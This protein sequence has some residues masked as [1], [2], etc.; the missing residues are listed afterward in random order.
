[1]NIR[2]QDIPITNPQEPFENCK[3]DR[4]KYAEV[5]IKIINSYSD[6]FVL[7][8]NNRWG[9]GKTTF[10]RMWIQYLV[11]QKY[12]TLYFNAWE[13]DFNKDPLAAI[14]SELKTLEI[15]DKNN[16]GPLI[17]KGAK[18]SLSILPVILEA[19]A[20]KYIEINTVKDAFKKLSEEAANIF[21]EEVNEYAEKKKSLVDFKLELENY[22]AKIPKKPLVFF[23][24]ELDRCNPKYAVELLE[25]IKHF[26]SVPGIVFIVSI[27]KE[28][29][30]NSIK[31]YFGSESI[32]SE[33]YLRRFFDLEYSIPKSDISLVVDWMLE[34]YSFKN[35]EAILHYEEFR[36]LRKLSIEYLGGNNFPIRLI[37][38][39]FL[40][41][42]LSMNTKNNKE[43]IFLETM[44]I[45]LL[46][47]YFDNN[48]Y[49]D[50][51][52]KIL[53]TNDFVRKISKFIAFNENVKSEFHLEKIEVEIAFLYS[54][55]FFRQKNHL[56][57]IRQNKD[58]KDELMYESNFDT[59][60]GYRSSIEEINRFQR[61]T[62]SRY[63]LDDIIN[64]I[65]L[66][67]PLHV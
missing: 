55:N 42:R 17:K 6:G 60:E 32:N 11:N 37:E 35:I 51:K 34:K 49:L 57:I 36:F 13:H 41:L 44:F 46:I 21:E 45:L 2:L 63:S 14:L 7:A 1:M 27:D 66:L 5:L 23:I 64:K 12:K 53:Q 9:E 62:I 47:K 30:S 29:L 39:F 22:V 15:Y 20:E 61:D 31:G 3:L 52:N 43:G 40:Q 10:I 24:D 50:I 16:F 59:S 48:L 65:E 28:Q 25:I 58:G 33:E 8:L 56:D 18:L 26:F 38:K 19:L 67:V 54:R 4:E